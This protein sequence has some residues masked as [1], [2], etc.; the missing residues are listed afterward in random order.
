M[1]IRFW[2][3]DQEG[4]DH[5][6]AVDVYE[7]QYKNLSNKNT[8]WDFGLDFSVSV[9]GNTVVKVRTFSIWRVAVCLT[10]RLRMSVYQAQ[11]YSRDLHPELYENDVSCLDFAAWSI[12]SI[13]SDVICI[14]Q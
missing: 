7:G 13:L 10:V 9:R 6:L 14:L 5:L 8:T 4:R 1:H 12:V 2:S 11:I 3:K